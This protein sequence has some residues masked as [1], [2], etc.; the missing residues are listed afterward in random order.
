MRRSHRPSHVR[1][2]TPSTP[3]GAKPS[4]GTNLDAG[5]CAVI[6]RNFSMSNG[7]LSRP[8]RRW[9][10][11]TGPDEQNLTDSAISPSSGA[12]TTINPTARTRSMACLSANVGP[13]GLV[14]RSV[15]HW[16]TTHR[17]IGQAIVD[18]IK[19]SRHH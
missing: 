5:S 18:Q 10:N 3:P 16:Q 4:I 9:R 19:Q 15:A 6:V 7:Q 8:I 13:S 14:A 2:S 17:L 1:R 12:N 11:S